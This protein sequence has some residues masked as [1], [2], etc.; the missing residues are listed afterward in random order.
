MF[1]WGLFVCEPK[2]L[3]DGCPF[4]FYCTGHVCS[5]E[6]PIKCGVNTPSRTSNQPLCVHVTINTSK[7]GE[8]TYLSDDASFNETVLVPP[9]KTF[10]EDAW[11]SMTDGI[12]VHPPAIE[13][14][15]YCTQYSVDCNDEACVS[16]NHSTYLAIC[17]SLDGSYDLQ[18]SVNESLVSYGGSNWVNTPF[19]ANV[20][21]H[22]LG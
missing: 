4:L 19:Y 2:N 7:L 15:R 3:C 9:P 12:I 13:P 11:F 20:V 16:T 5:D 1:A 17:I 21:I 14:F 22:D 18:V 10:S 6:P 8:V